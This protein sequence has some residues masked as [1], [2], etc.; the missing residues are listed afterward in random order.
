VAESRGT[1]SGSIA[2]EAIV[3]A[4]HITVLASTTWSYHPD[5]GGVQEK[6]L[7]KHAGASVTLERREVYGYG[8]EGE[9]KSVSTFNGT[10][11]DPSRRVVYTYDPVTGWLS[12]VASP[13]GQARYE[14]DARGRLTRLWTS[15]GIDTAYRYDALGR[16]EQVIDRGLASAGNEA[17][18][19]R[20]C[21]THGATSW[22]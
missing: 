14:R 16:I 4:T 1:V 11:S 5:W 12:G 19:V 15:T 8:D 20:L 6:H 21:A 10:S 13:E 7:Y 3:P 2:P 17:G 22:R 9:L 18:A